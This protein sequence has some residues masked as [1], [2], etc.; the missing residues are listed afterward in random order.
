MPSI[1]GIA[2]GGVCFS[3]LLSGALVARH[4]VRPK[5]PYQA[6]LAEIKKINIVRDRPTRAF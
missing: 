2:L 5:T 1:L 6:W 3:I 4:S